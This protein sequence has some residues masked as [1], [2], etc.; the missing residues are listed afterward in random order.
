ME[1]TEAGSSKVSRSKEKCGRRAY[2]TLGR[3]LPGSLLT[4]LEASVHSK[5]CLGYASC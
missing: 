3:S 1:M 5:C 2:P 4:S